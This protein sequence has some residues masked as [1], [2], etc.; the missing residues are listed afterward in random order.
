MNLGLLIKNRKAILDCLF[1]TGCLLLWFAPLYASGTTILSGWELS[2]EHPTTW[3]IPLIASIYFWSAWNGRYRIQLYSVGL[4]VLYVNIVLT[5]SDADRF[6]NVF[7]AWMMLLVLIGA[8]ASTIH[9][10]LD[11]LFEDQ[12][13]SVTP[14]LAFVLAFVAL[15]P[16]FAS[17]TSHTRNENPLYMFLAQKTGQAPPV[18]VSPAAHAPPVPETLSPT[19]VP[20]P[21]DIL[22][23]TNT[24]IF[25][26]HTQV[27]ELTMP[28]ASRGWSMRAPGAMKLHHLDWL[29]S[30]RRLA[31]TTARGDIYMSR[32]EGQSWVHRH[33]GLL[34]SFK[35]VQ[36]VDA[37]T[38]WA[39]GKSGKGKDAVAETRDGGVTWIVRE[40]RD[41]SKRELGSVIGLRFR[42]ARNGALI[43][44]N[45]LFATADAGETWVRAVSAEFR[46]S[47]YD[48]GRRQLITR[49]R[50]E[51]W[52]WPQ[53]DARAEPTEVTGLFVR[54][55]QSGQAAATGEEGG[56]HTND[57]DGQA[58]KRFTAP[59][60]GAN[61]CHILVA[62]NQRGWLA[63]CDGSLHYTVDGGQSW[64]AVALFNAHPLFAVQFIDWQTG[65]AVGGAGTILRTTDGGKNWSGHTLATD[66]DLH[67][68]RFIDAKIGWVLSE[69]GSIW[70]TRDGGLVWAVQRTGSGE[71]KWSNIHILDA[72]RGWIVGEKGRLLL[73][74]DGGKHWQLRETTFD[75]S[76][77]S[78]VFVDRNF[79]WAVGERGLILHSRDGGLTWKDQPIHMG[80]PLTFVAFRDRRNGWAVG[81]SRFALK[82]VDGG[83][84][85]KAVTLPGEPPYRAIR[86]FDARRGWLA[87]R[88]DWYRTE[89]GGTSWRAVEMPEYVDQSS[90]YVPSRAWFVD[91]NTA[92][93]VSAKGTIWK[94]SM[95]YRDKNQ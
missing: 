26:L 74:V 23:N 62:G 10:G 4:L 19:T 17:L 36:F 66:M 91:P 54:D 51:T 6:L 73:T 53:R 93:G 78:V 38:A 27:C 46:E 13:R 31:V 33:C 29:P 57:D 34:F 32:D 15:T 61:I 60:R 28:L 59:L 72:E 70:H 82:T 8:L 56:T 44:G 90:R 35:T 7:S 9:Q 3:I 58:P 47:T 65:W 75:E 39:T 63:G 67:A 68:L 77:R 12:A 43:G 40:L 80:E 89:D 22:S 76:L 16:V 50:G 24:S 86:F 25:M 79:G 84:N 69:R 52:L 87:G 92:W 94:Y 11:R 41:R 81:E 42:D 21:T 30:A 45:C 64:G 5:W 85:W 1:A 18:V 71:H 37:R 20:V 95:D 55:A 2:R 48:L 49:D 14:T 88:S 83:Q